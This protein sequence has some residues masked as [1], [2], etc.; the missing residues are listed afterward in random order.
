MPFHLGS[1]KT[2]GLWSEAMQLVCSLSR[3]PA[4]FWSP[5]PL[6]PRLPQIIPRRA[7]LRGR[8]VI[9]SRQPPK[10]LWGIQWTQAFTSFFCKSLSKW[11]NWSLWR[12]PKYQPFAQVGTCRY[13]I[14]YIAREVRKVLLEVSKGYLPV[15]RGGIWYIHPKPE[16]VPLLGGAIIG[17]IPRD[18]NTIFVGVYK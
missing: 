9:V 2:Y 6:A 14:K 7:W 1:F 15:E 12:L 3:T 11:T 16:K 13:F 4:L 5:W 18:F 10:I 8:S 17:I